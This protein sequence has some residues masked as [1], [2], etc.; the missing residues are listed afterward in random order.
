MYKLKII[1]ADRDI[2]YLSKIV[3][4]LNS[5]ILARFKVSAFSK[6]DVLAD[7][8]H[9]ANEQ[10]NI[11]LAHPDFLKLADDYYQNVEMILQLSDGSLD[12][13]SD[14]FPTVNKYIPADKMASNL[15][16]F[17]TEKNAYAAKLITGSKRTKLVAVYSASGGT[18]KSTMT[19]GLAAKLGRMEKPTLVLSFESLNSI[20]A[21]FPEK[22]RDAFSRLVFTAIDNPGSLPVKVETC[23]NTDTQNNFEFITAPECFYVMSELRDKEAGLLLDG[24]K[25][26]SKYDIVLA[27]ME[28]KPDKLALEI[29]R[30]SDRIIFVMTPDI[31]C[32]L[33]T[34]Q[35]LQQVSREENSGQTG[36]V[37]KLLPVINK[38]D[39]G[40]KGSWERYGLS[41]PFTVPACP[42]LWFCDNGRYRFNPGERFF[43]S[44]SGIAN[45][46]TEATGL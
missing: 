19:L 33:K 15:V 23:K 34:D 37:D 32:T 43:D 21:I 14:K 35:F 12:C 28:S 45:A 30:H 1:I 9:S 42:E 41:C 29:L 31:C 18:G 22:G 8:L 16:K 44:L 27:D 40:S 3:D 20:F 2:K 17:Y 36:F 4:Y 6:P 13:F 5:A 24:L 7:Y 11:L 10:I 38:Y 25:Q 26:M 39:G 46:L